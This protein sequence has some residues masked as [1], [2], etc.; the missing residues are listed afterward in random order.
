MY[1]RV[2][3]AVGRYADLVDDETYFVMFSDHGGGSAPARRFNI[4]RWLIEQ[5]LL[6]LR[7]RLVDR[8]GVASGLNRMIEAARRLRLH[9][10]L[11]R[12]LRGPVREGVL[13]LTRNDAFVDWTES[14]AYGVDFF[15]PLA[16]VEIN[17]KGRQSRGV[18]APGAEYEGL[19]DRIRAGLE[20]LVDPATGRKACRQV[21]LREEMFHGPRVER[22]PDV[23]AVL[24]LDF[25]GKVQLEPEVFPDNTLQWDYPYMGYQSREGFFAARGPGIAPGSTLPGADMIQLAPT[26]LELMG[27]PAPN[28]MEGEPLPMV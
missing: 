27:V 6:R 4:N 24:D 1:E 23:I 2:D 13:S 14:F 10:A 26:L 16:G 3:A 8:L 20:E 22:I 21:A 18:V 15:Y 28:S 19:R 7:S 11:R 12:Y 9:D 17:V 5:D 25:D